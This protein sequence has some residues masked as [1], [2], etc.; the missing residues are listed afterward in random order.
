MKVKKKEDVF[1]QIPKYHEI[2]KYLCGQVNVFEVVFLVDN[3]KYRPCRRRPNPI[4]KDQMDD[5]HS[6]SNV[7]ISLEIE[8]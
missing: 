5:E 8:P 4:F 7:S 2:M 1:I 6:V 3:S